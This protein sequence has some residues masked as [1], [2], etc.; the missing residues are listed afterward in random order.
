[1]IKRLYGLTNKKDAIKQIAK[2]YCRQESF[3]QQEYEQQEEADA[4]QNGKLEDHHIISPSR[5]YPVALFPFLQVSSE[6]PAK[7]VGV[8]AIHQAKYTD[9]FFFRI[10]SQSS[11]ITF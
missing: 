10:S 9:W 7:K 4:A 1:V 6:D 3:R 11:K 5:N 8:L 2:K